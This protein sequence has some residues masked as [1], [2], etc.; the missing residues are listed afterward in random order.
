MRAPLFALLTTSA[1]ACG[2]EAETRTVISTPES[3]PLVIRLAPGDGLEGRSLEVTGGHLLLEGC[4]RGTGATMFLADM[5]ALSGLQTTLLGGRWCGL[6]ISLGDTATL[7]AIN[8]RGGWLSAPMGGVQTSLRNDDGINVSGQSFVLE[9]GHPGWLDS[10]ALETAD[11]TDETLSDDDPRLSVLQAAL[12]TGTAL[13]TD[14]D[15]NG[16]LGSDERAEVL[17]EFS[18]PEV[19]DT[20]THDGADSGMTPADSGL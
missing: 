4:A 14:L 15:G 11:G 6:T 13:Y 17:A 10:T 19:G 2:K 20:G 9:L 7:R 1:L 8:H 12:I 18:A 16:V 5:T 3:S